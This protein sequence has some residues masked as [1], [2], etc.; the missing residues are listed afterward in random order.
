MHDK[1]YYRKLVTDRFLDQRDSKVD[2][3]Q[4]LIKKI[5]K[6]EAFQQAQVIALYQAFSDEPDLSGMDFGGKMVVEIPQDPDDFVF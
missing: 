5:L 6:N 3:D 1:D 2:R 4:K